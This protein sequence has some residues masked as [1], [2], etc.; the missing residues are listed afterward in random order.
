MNLI[1]DTLEIYEFYHMSLMM[2]KRY[3]LSGRQGRY[4][5]L[6]C[7]KYSNLKVFR[8]DFMEKLKREKFQNEQKV[9]SLLAHEAIHNVLGLIDANYLKMKPFGVALTNENSLG[10][11]T[12]KSMLNLGFWKKLV[13]LLDSRLSLHL[14]L[15]FCDFQNFQLITKAFM[16]HEEKLANKYLL[17]RWTLKVQ[18]KSFM[19]TKLEILANMERSSQF[20]ACVESL[21]QQ[22][23]DL[24]RD[25][26]LN[27]KSMQTI[28]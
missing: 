5:V 19:L 28:L 23:Q 20:S 11:Q 3:N 17:E 7:S 27:Q 21:E 12:Y 15:K 24:V 22:T 16:T 6:M 26:Q 14:C 10:I 2:C 8:A 1:L 25:V 9:C 4:L 18:L 13:Y